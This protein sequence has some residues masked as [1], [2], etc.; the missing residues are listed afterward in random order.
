MR[1]RRNINIGWNKR[2]H[3]ID[4]RLT[5]PRRLLTVRLSTVR[6]SPLRASKLYKM[7]TFIDEY[8]VNFAPKFEGGVH[9]D[10][11]PQP[12]V[13]AEAAPAPVAAK[14][15]M[16]MAERFALRSAEAKA[17]GTYK[18]VADETSTPEDDKVHE[19]IAGINAKT[20]AKAAEARAAEAA[21]TAAVEAPSTS[22]ASA[23]EAVDTRTEADFEQERKQMAA[24]MAMQA[25][26]AKKKAAERFIE[27]QGGI[28]EARAA[29]M[30]ATPAP[31]L[32]FMPEVVARQPEPM[33]TVEPMRTL[34]IP[35]FGDAQILFV[36]PDSQMMYFA[37]PTERARVDKASIGSES[38]GSRDLA[39]FSPDT[40]V[41]LTPGQVRD[42]LAQQPVSPRSQ[43]SIASVQPAN[44]R[45]LA[46]RYAA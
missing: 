35:K 12:I 11:K 17:A 21:P 28:A 45:P 9:H 2:R 24:E 15:R 43:E 1:W 26:A 6:S 20:E 14:P 42:L 8:M 33:P 37:T 27:A 29:L 7:T 5:E 4:F 19:L 22:E 36:D 25:V 31:K 46:G 18:D 13:A 44:S 39:N 34:K 30:R 41:A 38:Q 23:A 40:V 32:A 16:G 10:V 3:F